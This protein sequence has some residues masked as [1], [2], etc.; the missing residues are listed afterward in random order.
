MG[1]KIYIVVKPQG[2]QTYL[3]LKIN[4]Y[5]YITLIQKAFEPANIILIYIIYINYSF[6]LLLYIY[7][8]CVT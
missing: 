8:I 1:Q 6:L 3:T 4:K 5:I 2:D 7:N